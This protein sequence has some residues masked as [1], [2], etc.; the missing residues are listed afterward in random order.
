MFIYNYLLKRNY[1]DSSLSFHMLY[2]VK[3]I[4][5]NH[6]FDLS[7]FKKLA[8]LPDQLNYLEFEAQAKSVVGILVL[9][10]AF[11]PPSTLIIS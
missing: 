8:S 5:R 2:F 3:K 1:L 9:F 10:I 7:F 4:R 11:I 6:L